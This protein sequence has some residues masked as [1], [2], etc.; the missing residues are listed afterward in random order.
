LFSSDLLREEMGGSY[1]CFRDGTSFERGHWGSAA[2]L[3]NPAFQYQDTLPTH[4]SQV[5]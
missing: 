3:L 4:L 1:I 5:A 2:Q